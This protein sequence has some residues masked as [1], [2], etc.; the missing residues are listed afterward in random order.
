M[1]IKQAPMRSREQVEQR[2]SQLMATTP[3]TARL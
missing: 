2:L 3:I 1:A